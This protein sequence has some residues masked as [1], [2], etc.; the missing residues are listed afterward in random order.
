LVL[1]PLV[2]NNSILLEQV[3]ITLILFPLLDLLTFIVEHWNLVR[4]IPTKI[5]RRKEMIRLSLSYIF[6]IKVHD[7]YLLVKS[8]R[9]IKYQPPGGVYKVHPEGNTRLQK[10]GVQPDDRIKID[11]DSA[12]D[13]RILVPRAKVIDVLKW[14]YDR[15]EREVDQWREF[16]EELISTKILKNEI[17]PYISLKH[18]TSHQSKIKFSNHN[19]IDEI[20]VHEVYELRPTPKQQAELEGL[21]K[22]YSGKEDNYAW[23]SDVKLKSLGRNPV[24][25]EDELPVG[26]HSLYII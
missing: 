17:F 9:T 24:T 6:R 20:L 18:L 19:N 21:H 25:K 12:D 2:F 4:L 10:W 15:K 13:L 3:S 26:E 11:D 7:H 22:Q 14:F 23:V 8:N 1:N 16:H 5:F